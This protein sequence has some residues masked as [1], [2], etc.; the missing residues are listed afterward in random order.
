VLQALG[1]SPSA[2]VRTHT[3]GGAVNVDAYE[4]SLSILPVSGTT[5]AFTAPQLLVTELIHAAPGTEVLVGPDV[6]LQG[7]LNVDG[8]KG[9][10]SFTF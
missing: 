4:V 2:R 3:A 10:F 5:P 1:L 6:I 9:T 8:P 7:V